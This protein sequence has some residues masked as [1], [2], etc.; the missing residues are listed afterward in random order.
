MTS[1]TIVLLLTLSTVLTLIGAAIASFG[2]T[3]LWGA[4]YVGTPERIAR[5]MVKL[6]NGKPGE[7]LMDLGS[8][9]G[10]ILIVAAREFGM[11]AIGYELNPLLRLATRIKARWYGV[12]DLVEVRSGNLFHVDLP[13]AEVITLFLLE[14]AIARLRPKLIAQISLNTRVVAR[15]FHLQNWPHYAEDGWLRAYRK[16]DVL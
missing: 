11:K 12:G 10:A 14:P 7:T 13:P 16:S 2:L 15:D 6:A 5:R 4:P 1:L 8:G 3:G 9:A